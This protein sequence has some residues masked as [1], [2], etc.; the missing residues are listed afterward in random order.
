MQTLMI[1]EFNPRF[2]VLNVKHFDTITYDDGLKSQMYHRRKFTT[3]RKI[4]FICPK[5]IEQGHNDIGQECMTLS[6]VKILIDEG[7]EIGAH[8]YSH[9]PLETFDSLSKQV[10]YM[11]QD[12]EACIAWFKEH[13]GTV[14]TSFCFPYN[15]DCNEVYRAIVKKYKFTELF[16]VNR[17]PI[18]TLPHS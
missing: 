10:E 4:F 5:F 15:N 11:T 13:I 16:G 7:Y 12:T 14:P 2:V 18:E 3:K 9:T 17:I 8:S 6:D 1:H